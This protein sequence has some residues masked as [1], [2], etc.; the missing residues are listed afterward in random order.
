MNG[1][2]TWQFP[3]SFSFIFNWCSIVVLCLFLCLN[4]QFVLS[5]FKTRKIQME[6]CALRE[7]QEECFF[8]KAEK[9][10]NYAFA[11]NVETQGIMG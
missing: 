7:L 1:N 9:A 5:F 6:I 10:V 8:F 2:V 11:L 3:S 4:S